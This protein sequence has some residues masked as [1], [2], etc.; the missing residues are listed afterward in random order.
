MRTLY[1]AS[2]KTFAVMKQHKETDF[3]TYMFTGLR[4]CNFGV[5]KKALE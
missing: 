3:K 4:T 5:I 2:N 1:I